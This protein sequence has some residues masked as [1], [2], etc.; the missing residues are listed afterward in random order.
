[1]IEA[2]KDLHNAGNA[3]SVEAWDGENLAGG[4]YGI[5]I[6][7][8]FFGESMFSLKSDAS[9]VA[10]ATFVNFSQALGI[11]MFDCQV[12]TDHLASLGA[13]PIPREEDYIDISIEAG[14]KNFH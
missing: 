2:Y 9:K 13:C 6:G 1:M 10:F 14:E 3:Y 11:C 4:L 7:Q 5:A 8:V 12:Y